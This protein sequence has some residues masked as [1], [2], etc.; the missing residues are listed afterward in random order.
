M[1]GFIAGS[2]VPE[3]RPDLTENVACMKTP[4]HG[5][6]RLLAIVDADSLRSF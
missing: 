5:E 1:D 6:R 4:G 3:N 2:M